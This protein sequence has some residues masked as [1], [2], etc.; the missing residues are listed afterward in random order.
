MMRARH[1]VEPAQVVVRHDT[2]CRVGCP[3]VANPIALSMAA[4]LV[5]GTDPHL[6]A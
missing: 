5:A 4:Q 2:G 1:A 6:S 3:V